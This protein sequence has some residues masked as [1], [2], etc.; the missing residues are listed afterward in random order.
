M[1]VL[2]TDIAHIKRIQNRLQHDIA[3][4]IAPTRCAHCN[5]PGALLCKDCQT[6]LERIDQRLACPYCGAPFGWLVC[7]ECRAGYEESSAD[8]A[9]GQILTTDTTTGASRTK[10]LKYLVAATTFKDVAASLVV[11]FKDAHEIRLA[12]VLAYYMAAAIRASPYADLSALDAMCFVP[13]TQEAYRRRGFDHME[14]VAKELSQ[15]LKI[16]LLD[17]LVRDAAQDQ[18]V[19]GREERKENLKDTIHVLEEFE[20]RGGG[21]LQGRG[22]DEQQTTGGVRRISNK[23]LKNLRWLVIDDVCTTGA[24]LEEA[25]RALYKKGAQEVSALVFARVW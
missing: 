3:E 24:S 25:T 14:Y 19:L 7:T 23:K 1:L 21:G 18:R 20:V 4:L 10:K 9:H 11:V 8:V 5:R 15:M 17:V 12:R 13:A 16:P 6:A 2:P 22:A